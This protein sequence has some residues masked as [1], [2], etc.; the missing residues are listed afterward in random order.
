MNF[1]H[2]PELGGQYSYFIC[3]L[4]MALIGGGMMVWFYKKD[5]LSKNTED[6]LGVFQPI[7]CNTNIA[8]NKH[9]MI[10]IDGA[11]SL[12]FPRATFKIG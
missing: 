11:T 9:V 3:L 6:F 12:R 2:M 4:L 8:K 5:G 10:Y 7:A 1:T